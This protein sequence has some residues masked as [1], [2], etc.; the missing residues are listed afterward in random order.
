M[1]PLV[2]Q[3]V[4]PGGQEGRKYR[5]DTPTNLQ[6]ATHLDPDFSLTGKPADTPFCSTDSPLYC[7]RPGLAMMML[8]IRPGLAMMMLC[9]AC[10]VCSMAA[11]LWCGRSAA[12]M[13]WQL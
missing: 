11:A 13:L 1:L 6:P 2:G 9:G 12:C 3:H 4:L 7:I 8:C 10:W 5:L